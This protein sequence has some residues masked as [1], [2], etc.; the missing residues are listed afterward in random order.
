MREVSANLLINPPRSI[1]RICG[2]LMQ[3]S[4]HVATISCFYNVY[5][6]NV[7]YRFISQVLIDSERN[8]GPIRRKVGATLFPETFSRFSFGLVCTPNHRHHPECPV[9][10]FQTTNSH[11]PPKTTMIF[12]VFLFNRIIVRIVQL[13]NKALLNTLTH[14]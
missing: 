1:K 9:A 11:G 3:F 4:Q 6:Y 7:N 12:L 13:A 8:T 10:F 5:L 2:L 14:Y